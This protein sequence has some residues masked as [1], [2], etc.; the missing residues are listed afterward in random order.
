MSGVTSTPRSRKST[1]LAINH[2][3]TVKPG[4][5]QG[6]NHELRDR[7]IHYE[8]GIEEYIIKH[9]PSNPPPPP[10]LANDDLT[11]VFDSWVPG[12]QKEVDTY[13]KIVRAIH[14]RVRPS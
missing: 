4:V 13:P 7:I 10:D 3:N 8:G 5:A 14:A 6:W 2:D 12:A 1:N 9:V 11:D